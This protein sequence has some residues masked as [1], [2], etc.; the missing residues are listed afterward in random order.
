MSR[1]RFQIES[2]VLPFTSPA[3]GLLSTATALALTDP[4]WRMGLQWQPLCPDADGTYGEC[5]RLDGTPLVAPKDDTWSWDTRGATP[6][7]VYSRIDCAPVGQW[8]DLSDKNRQALLRSEER[9]LERIFWTGEAVDGSG[10]ISVFPHLTAD[11]AVADGEDLMQPPVVL[12][13]NA[14]QEIVIGLGMLEAAMR[15]CYPGVATI[16]MP[17][18]LAAIAADHH[19]IEAR[20]GVMYTTTVGSRVV[21]GDYPGTAPDGT[22]PAAGE[23]WMY[24]TGAVFYQREPV[25]HT[26]TPVES[27]DRSVNTLGMIAERTYVI[28]W[29]CCLMGIAIL[30]G[31]LETP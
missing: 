21:I 11:T 5:T 24:A 3:Y 6:V 16:H 20:N 10:N 14:A 13:S 1:G 4:H 27:F 17:I 23:T 30:N 7:T 15:E 12:A 25:P 29:D 18:R 22:E 2:D 31:E 9:E 28:G 26:F 19:L 8:D